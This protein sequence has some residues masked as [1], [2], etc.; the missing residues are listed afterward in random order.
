[1]DAKLYVP[2]K[3]TKSESY[4]YNGKNVNVHLST[5][6]KYSREKNT[7]DYNFNCSSRKAT[8]LSKKNYDKLE[9]SILC[10]R[11]SDCE[12]SKQSTDWIQLIENGSLPVLNENQ[13]DQSLNSENGESLSQLPLLSDIPTPECPDFFSI[14]IPA[15]KPNAKKMASPARD[16][17][18]EKRRIK[19]D[20]DLL[21][22]LIKQ[23]NDNNENRFKSKKNESDTLL[24]YIHYKKES[25][26]GAKKYENPFFSMV[27]EACYAK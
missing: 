10:Y 18:P 22:N 2:E 9:S 26:I 13:S 8:S 14:K 5:H 4:F 6:T 19:A 20:N 25:I 16:E 17:S 24:N 11:A 12:T 23:I 7:R 3:V 21:K 15:L 27:K 1:M